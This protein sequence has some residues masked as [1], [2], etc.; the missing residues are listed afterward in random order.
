MTFL[1]F[2]RQDKGEC[3][4]LDFSQMKRHLERTKNAKHLNCPK[5]CRELK[6]IFKEQDIIDKYGYNLKTTEKLYIDTVVRK[7]FAFSLFASFSTMKIIKDYID[8]RSRKYLIDGTFSCAPR[9]YYQLLIILIE[10]KN[11]VSLF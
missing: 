2:S 10:Y 4:K 1:N 3:S 6:K 11:D 7:N 5:T 8:P 9:L